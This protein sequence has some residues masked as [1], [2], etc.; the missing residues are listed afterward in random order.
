LNN[1]NFILYYLLDKFFFIFHSSLIIFNLFGWVWRKTRKLNLLLLSLT[2][3]SWFFLG[4]WYGF[5]YC[6]ST[7]WHWTIRI[8]LGYF[9]MSDSYVNFLIR[10]ITGIKLSSSL[11]DMI[12]LLF[13]LVALFISIS[14]NYKDI[15]G[16]K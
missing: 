13:F 11:A 9:D 16:K 10:K 7:D 1:I 4:I 14:L 6:P 5:G 12:T 2:G 8:K 3:F 15:F